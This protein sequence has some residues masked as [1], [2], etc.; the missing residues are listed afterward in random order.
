MN[1]SETYDDQALQKYLS[2]IANIK[3]LSREEENELARKAKNGDKE[4]LNKLVRANLKF[5]V[6]IASHYQGKGLSFAELISEGNI[7]LIKAIQKFDTTKGNKLITYAVW[8]IRQSILFALAEKTRLI[9]VPLNKAGDFNKIKKSQNHYYK[10]YG[11]KIDMEDLSDETSIDKGNIINTLNSVHDIIPIDNVSY[12]NNKTAIPT[13]FANDTENPQTLYY[14]KKLAQ[15]IK[16]SLK[17]LNKRD[18]HIIK[19]Y[20]GLDDVQNGSGLGITSKG[21]NFAQIGEEIGLSR[22]RVRQLQKEALKK[23]RKDA[24]PEDDLYIDYLLQSG[25]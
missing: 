18:Y 25:G 21:K 16:K 24:N 20:F 7:G 6:K 19:E 5:V 10:E 17:S 1:Q 4:A 9:R 23:I 8:W 15:K 14:K 12:G 13:Q 3:P 2:D 11:E 22:E